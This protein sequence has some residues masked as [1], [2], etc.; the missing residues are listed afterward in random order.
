MVS[1]ATRLW[2]IPS[3]K[4]TCAAI[5][6]VHRLESYPNSLG[7]G[8]SISRNRSALCSSKA[9]RVRFGREDPASRASRPR[10]LNAWMAFLT[11]WEPHPK[12]AAILGEVSPRELARSIWHRHI[13]TLRTIRS[14]PHRQI[15]SISA[16]WP[17]LLMPSIL[18]SL[19]RIDNSFR[20]LN[21]MSQTAN[22]PLLRP[23]W[24]TGS[25]R[26]RCEH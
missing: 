1:P 3:S 22:Y 8:W 9:A 15:F 18:I 5:S 12:L 2:T 11:V 6:S 20:I 13:P 14:A 10:L 24:R 16:Y 4:A 21:G 23:A 19:D 17:G 25:C 26:R 7:E